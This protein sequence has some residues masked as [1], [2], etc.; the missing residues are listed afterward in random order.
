MRLKPI[1][2]VAIVLSLIFPATL[3]AANPKSGAKC[4]KAGITQVYSGKIFTCVKSGKNLVWNKGILI[5]PTTSP[6]QTIQPTPAPTQTATSTPTPTP[7]TTPTPITSVTPTPMPTVANIDWKQIFTTDDGYKYLYSNPCEKDKFIQPVWLELQDAYYKL[8][9]CVWP[10]AIAKFNLGSNR[11]STNFSNSN[12]SEITKCKISELSSSGS[13]RGFSLNWSQDR[14]AWREKT[15]IPGPRMTIQIIPI[16]AEDTAIPVNSPEADYSRYTSFLK[17]WAEYSSDNGSEIQIRYP[18]NYI[19][20]NGKIGSYGI[21]HEKRHDSP[22]HQRFNKEI[23]SQVDPFIDFTGVNLAIFVTPAGTSFSVFKQGTIGQLQT[24]EGTVMTSTT[25]YPYTLEDIDSDKF[26]SMILPYW[27]IHE[28]GHSAIGLSDHY[29]DGQRNI[30]TEYGLGWWSLMT[31]G[32]G[33][34]TAWEKWFL[35]F[36]SDSQVNCMSPNLESQTWIAPSSVKTSEKKLT[37]VPLSTTKGIAIES[38]RSAGL[39]YKLPKASNGVLIYEIDLANLNHDQGLK[40]VLPT[41][42]N[43]DQGPYFLAEATLRQ[44]ESVVSNSLRITVVE[45][46]TFGDVVKVEKA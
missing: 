15:L 25:E 14:Q 21:Y 29:G 18:K 37:I 4:S 13:N 8:Q 39:Y 19:K 12:T 32:G 16:Y 42:R 7:T 10:M 5:K 36:L 35:G 17:E 20:V 33:D 38:I 9:N 30:N 46:G 41:N 45:S 34:L 11:P 31:P 1:A 44:G 2:A 27:W 6:S 40:L 43:P 3:F 28:L 22:E 23:T 26:K 24:N